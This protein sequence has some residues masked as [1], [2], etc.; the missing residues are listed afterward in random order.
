MSGHCIV[1]AGTSWQAVDCPEQ[2]CLVGSRHF[3]G[4]G[5][6]GAANHVEL[7]YYATLE[8]CCSRLKHERHCRIVGVEIMS[9]AKAV[10]EHPFSGPTAFMLGNEVSW[11]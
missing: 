4:F 11:G 7:D 6:H 3:N 2:V 9:T 10:H 5:S 1:I 8:D